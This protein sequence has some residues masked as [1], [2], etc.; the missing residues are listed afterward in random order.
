MLSIFAAFNFNWPSELQDLYHSLSVFSFN[1]EILAP[2]CSFAVNYEDKWLVTASLPLLLLLAV[3]IVLAATRTLQ[4]VQSNVFSVI[5]F[6]AMSESS[7]TDVCI[8]ILITGSYYLYFRTWGG[9][10]R[11]L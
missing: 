10:A 7:L 11:V 6:G 1:L 8:G 3:A 9:L 5:P 2:E 4:W